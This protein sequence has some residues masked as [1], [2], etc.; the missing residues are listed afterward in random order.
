MI[1][2]KKLIKKNIVYLLN[3]LLQNY[4]NLYIP[5]LKVIHN[6]SPNYHEQQLKL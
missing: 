5:K 2:N 4:N 3:I 1:K 6:F